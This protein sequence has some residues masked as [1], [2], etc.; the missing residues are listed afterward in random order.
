LE[1]KDNFLLLAQGQV[2]MALGQQALSREKASVGR[3][4]ENKLKFEL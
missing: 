4:P 1:N 3:F 2:T